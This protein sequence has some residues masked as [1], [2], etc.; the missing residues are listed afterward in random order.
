MS[1]TSPAPQAVRPPGT[2][3]RPSIHGDWIGGALTAAAIIGAAIWALLTYLGYL[4]QVDSFQRMTAP[5]TATVHLTQATTRVLYYE[6]PGPV[7]SLGQFGIHVTGPAGT[8]V[9]VNPY[10]TELIYHAPLVNPTRTGTAIA[11]FDPT[12]SGDYRINADPTT[13]TRGTI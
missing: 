3:H 11:S 4:N 5:G 7:P 9:K 2:P 13:G 12:T 1:V 8:A 10:T 6:S